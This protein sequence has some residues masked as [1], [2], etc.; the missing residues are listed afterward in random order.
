MAGI[1]T[2]PA[3]L[4]VP[5]NSGPTNLL[6]GLSS[7]F[8][9]EESLVL[10]FMNREAIAIRVQIKMAELEVFALGPVAINTVV[11]DTPGAEKSTLAWFGMGQATHELQIFLTNTSAG[12]LEGR[13]TVFIVPVR[14]LALLPQLANILA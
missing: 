3:I 4:D 13:T 10:V 11:G 9:A 1:I 7:R 5:A 8:M 2:I 6:D 12:L 14:M